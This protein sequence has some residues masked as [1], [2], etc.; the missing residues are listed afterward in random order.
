MMVMHFS[1]QFNAVGLES[2]CTAKILQEILTFLT[3][4]AGQRDFFNYSGARIIH[5]GNG[6]LIYNMDSNTWELKPFAPE[7]HSRNR[8]NIIDDYVFLI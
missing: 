3:A 6:V 7:F 2:K 4:N 1:R 8:S 5:C